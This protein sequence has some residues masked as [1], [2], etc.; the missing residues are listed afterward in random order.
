MFEQV[1]N[2]Y[3]AVVGKFGTAV[4]AFIIV[5]GFLVVLI[6]FAHQVWS[7]GYDRAVPF[8][9]DQAARFMVVVALCMPLPFFGAGGGGGS[10]ITEYPVVILKA[11]FAAGNSMIGSL[12]GP[13]QSGS[14]KN[15][16]TL[17]ENLRQ[18][19]D[20][21]SQAQASFE[22]K[23]KQARQEISE[24]SKQGWYDK[25]KSAITGEAFLIIA[26]GVVI[27][28]VLSPIL[29]P[30]ISLAMLILGAKVIPLIALIWCIIEFLVLALMDPDK[31]VPTSPLLGALFQEI[32]ITFAN[33]MFVAILTFTYYGVLISIMI[34][35][36]IYCIS[37]PLTCGFLA[38]EQQRSRVISA[39]IS[40]VALAIS[41]MIATIVFCIAAQ[42]YSA[43]L[44]SGALD[45]MIETFVG[46]ANANQGSVGDWV[47]LFFRWILASF[48]APIVLCLPIARLVAQTHRIAN[49]VVSGGAGGM[50]TGLSGS[51]SNA[52]GFGRR[53]S[54]G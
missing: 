21:N 52:G 15:L 24:S 40:G 11:G 13:A 9:K 48:L 46:T 26:L 47:A 29:I 50:Q 27:T 32:A 19:I 20:K 8:L 54:G 12:P 41:P 25:L 31:A 28:L 17:P 35:A 42:T 2:T 22:A 36:I 10:F 1:L 37:F 14:G 16:L 39:V 23:V 7:Q 3:Q 4:S 18:F 43:L 30:K 34:R 49:E 33:F 53:V 38:F 6:R 44:G 51:F 5:V 45:T